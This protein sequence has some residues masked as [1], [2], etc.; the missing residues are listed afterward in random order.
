MPAE[1]HRQRQQIISLRIPPEIAVKAAAAAKKLKM[2]K[3]DIYRLATDR[4]IDVLLEQLLSHTKPA[5]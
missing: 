1:K 5:A 2:K 3:S 4:G